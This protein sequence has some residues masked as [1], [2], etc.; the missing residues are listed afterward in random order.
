MLLGERRQYSK[1]WGCMMSKNNS[2]TRLSFLANYD[3][4]HNSAMQKP[5]GFWMKVSVEIRKKAIEKITY[6]D[7][8]QVNFKDKDSDNR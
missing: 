3:D 1:F 8:I 5:I 7:Q 4:F 6:Y 2:K